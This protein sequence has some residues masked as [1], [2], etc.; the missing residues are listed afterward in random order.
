M[1][2][3]VHTLYDVYGAEAEQGTK[4]PEWIRDCG[5]NGRVVVCRDKLRHDNEKELVKEHGTKVFRIA[6]SA[7]NADQMIAYLQTNK[8][9]IVQASRKRGPFIYR[10]EA[11]SIV[12]IMAPTKYS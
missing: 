6:R 10:V 9:R 12:P 7:K 1:G 8:H 4:D 3:E 11:N 5:K 2:Y